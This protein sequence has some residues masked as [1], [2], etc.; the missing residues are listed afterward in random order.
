MCIIDTSMPKKT[1]LIRVLTAE[2]LDTLDDA[3]FAELEVDEERLHQIFKKPFHHQ[4][5]AGP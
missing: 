3:T 2:E 4:I 1:R 5:R